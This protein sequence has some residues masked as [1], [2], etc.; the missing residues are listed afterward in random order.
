MRFFEVISAAL[1]VAAIALLL[2]RLRSRRLLHMTCLLLVLGFAI[3]WL[4]EGL[5]WQLYPLYV[6]IAVVLICVFFGRSWRQGWIA[7]MSIAA[8]F[9]V[10]SSVFLSW[11]MPMFRLPA[12]TGRYAVGTQ[13]MHLVDTSRAEKNGPSPTGNRELMVQVWYPANHP[14][15][16]SGRRAAYQRRKE[17]TLRASYRS[18]LQT[19]SY[20]DAGVLPGGP[21][22][23]LIYNP[24][25]MG[26]RTESTFQME[27]LASH[28]F[29]VVGV[30]HTFFGG[31]VAFPDGRVEDSRGA[32][33]LGNFEHATVEEEWA[34]GS[35]YVHI[36]AQDDVFVLN[37]LE[38]M[39]RDPASPW[40]QKLDTTK[41]GAMGYSIG[42]A[43]AEQMAYQ[44]SRVKAALDMDG[45][46]FGDV[47]TRGLNI[48]LMVIF[49]E[50]SK[51]VPTEAQLQSNSIP[52]RRKWELSA[53]DFNNVTSGLKHTGG[54]LL[55]IAG[56]H[57]VD[58][59]D[60]SLLSPVRALTGAGTIDPV[61]A[62]T[63]I[64][65]Y[66]LA[67]FSSVLIG[68]DEPLLKT[69]PA[70]FPE[71]AFEYFAGGGR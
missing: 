7:L 60:R 49:E 5:H 47:A 50:K 21:Y 43:A 8:L 70:P 66:T 59:S 36:E 67:F 26:E 53:Q 58:F 61:R 12:P 15:S 4:L 48:P 25:W 32:P 45:W 13:I 71:V 22:P 69:A 52:E 57:H 51:T 56:T 24:S 23:V 38:A 31:L 63:I 39:N 35:K 6:A 68:Q 34:L 62:H 28:G 55:F 3:H 10:G 30:D 42:G 33:D 2:L 46:S 65:S 17:V 9:F 1:A 41:V 40:Y 11:M 19:Y 20:Q 37:Q 14:N 27:D 18:V 64:N 44:D 16:L 29:V 54:F